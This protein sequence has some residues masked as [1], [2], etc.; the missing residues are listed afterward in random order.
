M[1]YRRKMLMEVNFTGDVRKEF[2]KREFK[3]LQM[4]QQ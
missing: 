1:N 4:T 2:A 3:L